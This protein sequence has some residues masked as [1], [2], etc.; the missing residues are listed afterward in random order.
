MDLNE[1]TIRTDLKINM[2]SSSGYGTVYFFPENTI[3]LLNDTE[4][5]LKSPMSLEA[6][7]SNGN[8]VKYYSENFL[9]R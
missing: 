6:T 7:Y 1:K 4:L 2:S 9:E 8:K 3:V 5:L